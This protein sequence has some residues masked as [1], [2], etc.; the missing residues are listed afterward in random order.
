MRAL[1]SLGLTENVRCLSVDSPNRTTTT[2]L[3]RL[4]SLAAPDLPLDRLA[5]DLRQVLTL[6]SPDPF[7]PEIV[8]LIGWHGAP[9]SVESPE[10]AA[11]LIPRSPLAPVPVG[12][13]ADGSVAGLQLFGDRG[14][15]GLLVSGSPGSGKSALLSL[16]LHHYI[17]ATTLVGIDYKNGETLLPW[18]SCFARLEASP[19]EADTLSVLDQLMA[20]VA[21]R[22]SHPEVPV[23]EW[24]PLLLVVEELAGAP[25]SAKVRTALHRLAA[26]SRSSLIA[27]VWTTQRA[28][29]CAALTTA[30]RQQL[31]LR[32][33][34]F[35]SG[36]ADASEAA[37]GSGL[38]HAAGLPPTP[39]G[40][41]FL[42]GEQG[43]PR[44]VRTFAP[45][46]AL[47]LGN[48]PDGPGLYELA[49]KDEATI[50]AARDG[51][52]RPR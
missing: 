27:H 24:P 37:L 20:V 48:G 1:R 36:D 44:L 18:S 3:L 51:Y 50:R 26:L 23:T 38:K 21:R 11:V 25:D 33:A 4:R 45:I 28:T 14:S 52:L 22:S 43:M 5:V 32:A 29:A 17:G 35:C 39:P 46:R 12:V 6:E 47:G 49:A 7:R 40:L 31:A 34:F 9:E 15:V 42:L 8:R 13:H 41:C 16:L 30:L 2:Y 10:L 19:S